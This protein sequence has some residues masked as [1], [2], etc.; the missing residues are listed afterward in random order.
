[1]LSQSCLLLSPAK[2]L[3]ELL[4]QRLQIIWHRHAGGAQFGDAFVDV[5]GQ[6]VLVFG[7]P[8]HLVEKQI[9]L[10]FDIFE[11]HSLMLHGNEA[12]VTSCVRCN[13]AAPQSA[14]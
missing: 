12:G 2:A 4:F 6:F 11:S 10:R 8:G 7:L 14:G 3:I 13:I 9:D 1:M 5:A